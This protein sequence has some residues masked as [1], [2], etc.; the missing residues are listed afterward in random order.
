MKESRY[1]HRTSLTLFILTVFCLTG[2]FMALGGP[3]IY[4]DRSKAQA[5]KQTQVPSG[6]STLVPTPTCTPDWSPDADL[7]STGVGLV[8]VYFQANGKF[9]GMGGRSSDT[10]GNEFTHPFEYDP[11]SNSL[12]DQVGHLPRHTCEQH[13]LW[14]AIR[15][16]N[17]VHLLRGRLATSPP[18]PAHRSRLPL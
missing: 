17:A 1:R 4:S 7:P 3:G 8:G 15:R 10:A 6:P 5:A 18:P 13:G 16:W 14:R 11:N 9:Y 12:D 2:A